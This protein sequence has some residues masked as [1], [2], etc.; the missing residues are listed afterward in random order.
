LCQQSL[1]DRSLCRRV[2]RLGLVSLVH[3]PLDAI[4]DLSDVQVIIFTE[5]EAKS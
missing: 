2:G 1:P 5:W 3:A 4:P